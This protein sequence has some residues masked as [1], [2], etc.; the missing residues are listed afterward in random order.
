MN[1]Y[2]S[3]LALSVRSCS[4]NVFYVLHLRYVLLKRRA[5]MVVNVEMISLQI[6]F[7]YLVIVAMSQIPITSKHLKTDG[8]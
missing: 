6:F 1:D 3:A 8:H 7:G 5:S 4:T 2:T